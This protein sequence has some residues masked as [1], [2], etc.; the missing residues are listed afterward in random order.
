MIG[1]GNVRGFVFQMFVTAIRRK[2]V[3]DYASS[4]GHVLL[5]S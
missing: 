1:P 5:W 4:L 2:G 3:K